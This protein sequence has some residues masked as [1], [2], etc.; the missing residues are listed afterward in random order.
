MVSMIRKM[1]LVRGRLQRQR[2]KRQRQFSVFPPQIHLLSVMCWH[3]ALLII[4]TDL[5]FPTGLRDEVVS[6]GISHASLERA[7]PGPLCRSTIV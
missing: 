7:D 5:G 3:I 4:R 6:V 1:S 2:R